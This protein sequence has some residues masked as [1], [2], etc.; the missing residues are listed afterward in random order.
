MDES[1]KKKAIEKLKNVKPRN[2]WNTT[3]ADKE[4]FPIKPNPKNIP[5][6]ITKKDIHGNVKVRIPV[7]P[8]NEWWIDSKIDNY[9]FW[10]WIARNSTSDGKIEPMQQSEIGKMFG[11]SATKIHFIIKHTI[12]KLK[13]NGYHLILADYLSENLQSKSISANTSN[14]DNNSDLE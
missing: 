6:K 8:E 7:E 4:T 3:G 13:A 10:V 14:Y 2:Y 9:D 1:L 12:E 5:K 11:C